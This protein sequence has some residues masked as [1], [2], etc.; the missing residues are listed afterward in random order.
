MTPSLYEIMTKQG[1]NER[2]L[3]QQQKQAQ[4]QR[5]RDEMEGRI[6]SASGSTTLGSGTSKHQSAIHMIELD[7]PRT[8]PE[9][10]LFKKN[11]PMFDTLQAVLEVPSIC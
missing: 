2:V 6:P 1:K 9:L 8:F 4:K 10:H 3:D 7:V 11:G 5:I